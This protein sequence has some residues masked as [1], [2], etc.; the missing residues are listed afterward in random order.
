MRRLHRSDATQKAIVVA[1]RAIGA[2]VY[3]VGRPLDLLVSYRRRTLLVECK[4]KGGKVRTE[5]QQKFVN[6]WQ[7]EFHLVESPEQAITAVCGE[8]R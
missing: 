2:Q 5:A 8:K 6:E 4:A 1:L 7:G 3:V